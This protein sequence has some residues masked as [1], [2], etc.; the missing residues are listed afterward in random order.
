MTEA[1]DAEEEGIGTGKGTT[2]TTGGSL[3]TGG[4]EVETV[5]GGIETGVACSGK[6]EEGV[7]ILS[8]EM[9]E[10]EQGKGHETEIEDLVVWDGGKMMQEAVMALI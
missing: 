8:W 2:G 9:K 3:V 4:I 6:E 5:I 7:I 10:E 1:S